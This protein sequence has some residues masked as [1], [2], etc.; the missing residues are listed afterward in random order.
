MPVANC[1]AVV[2]LRILLTNTTAIWSTQ[3][4]KTRPSPT[5][6]RCNSE[7]KANLDVE[8][9]PCRRRETE[10]TAHGFN[11]LLDPVRGVPEI[12]RTD[13]KIRSPRGAS[14]NTPATGAECSNDNQERNC[15]NPVT[16]GCKMAGRRGDL[17]NRPSGSHTAEKRSTCGRPQRSCGAEWS[18]SSKLRAA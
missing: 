17:G 8:R 10:V 12:L 6:N 5:A 9:L 11:Q 16:D 18:D 2:P 3:A 1:S 7:C 15:E 4:M 14:R 13:A